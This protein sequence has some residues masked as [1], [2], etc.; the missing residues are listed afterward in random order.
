MIS[1]FRYSFIRNSE[2]GEDL[3]Q[4]RNAQYHLRPVDGKGLKP[5]PIRD[6]ETKVV[7]RNRRYGILDERIAANQLE[8]RLV[9]APELALEVK[10]ITEIFVK[11]RFGVLKM[12]KAGFI[13]YV[14]R[15][16][17]LYLTRAEG[18]PICGYVLS[19]GS[20]DDAEKAPS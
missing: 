8:C 5:I 11:D 4:L 17:V 13:G 12:L 15:G 10:A 14:Q 19:E 16:H 6:G 1:R 18:V 20:P 2:S 7:G 3:G 9:F